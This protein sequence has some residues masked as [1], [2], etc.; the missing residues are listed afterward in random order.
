MFHDLDLPESV[1]AT[2]EFAPVEDVV[3]PLVRDAL[4]GLRIFSEV[5][6]PELFPYAV[7]R[8]A[9]T[10]RFWSGDDRFVDWAGI[11][12]HV[13]ASDP[14]GERKAAIIS[15]AIRVALRDAW[16][17]QRTTEH[18][19]ICAYRMINRPSRRSDWATA[20]GPVQYADLPTGTQ[21]YESMFWLQIRRPV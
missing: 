3:L 10:E 18:G 12:V 15:D 14:D 13:F 7:V 9:H 2:A 8:T 21:R 11:S 16:L 20:T 19:W 5:P 6:E 1:L 4:P 17:E